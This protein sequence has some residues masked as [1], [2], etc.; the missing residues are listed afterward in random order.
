MIFA[1]NVAAHP[2]CPLRPQRVPQP[3]RNIK[4]MNMSSMMGIGG[5]RMPD[6][7]AMREKMF[8]KA[9]SNGDKAI[10]FEEFEGAGK[11]MPG[12]VGGSAGNAKEAFAKIDGDGNGSLSQEEMKSFGEKMSSGMQGMMIAMQAMMGGGGQSGGFGSM[13]GGQ[14][15]N[16]DAM[17]GKVDGDGNGSVSRA[18]F[19]KA[20]QDN[21]IMKLLG[22]DKGEA[23]GKIDADGDGSLSKDEMKSFA[24]TMKQQMQGGAQGDAAQRA[25][26]MKAMNAYTGGG[27]G[28]EDLTA[29]L[30]KMLDGGKNQNGGR[31][32]RA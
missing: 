21:P 6:F 7:S 10:S 12:G 18:E 19:D 15:P 23:F 26:Y 14:K 32:V 5:G 3:V 20:S 30:L 28:K 16:L 8:A 11:K 31:D 13:M 24:E 1:V 22:D 9:D 2:G 27:S 4:T 29:T 17:F 25:D